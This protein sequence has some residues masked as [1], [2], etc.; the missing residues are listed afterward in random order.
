MIGI[1][2]PAH[3]EEEKIEACLQ[4]LW[5]AAAH[6]DLKNEPVEILVMTDSCSDATG[7]LARS[8]GA[9][10]LDVRVRNVGMARQFGAQ[11]ALASGARW[12]AFT[13]ADSTVAPDWLV[14]QLAQKTD[15]V[16]G[17]VAVDDWSAYG[18]LMPQ[19][20]RHFDL[21]YIDRDG[22]SHVHGAN[23]G[24][25]ARAY[26]AAGGFESL[27]SGEDM[28]LVRRLSGQGARIAWSA[29]PRV[30]TSVR[31]DYRAPGGFGAALDRIAQL[32][33]WAAGSYAMAA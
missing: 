25:S 13:D 8:L 28:D 15:A 9:K 23:L 3:Q 16:C 29:A 24:V 21:T 32:G 19:M 4:S 7:Y 30:V 1:V 31:R 20:Q 6:P 22:H 27:A 26:H 10:T 17:T 33:Q 18:A 2:V 5:Q 14:A 12:L 11:V